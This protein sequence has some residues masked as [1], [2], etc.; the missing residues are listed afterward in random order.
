ME[1]KKLA[2]DP[3]KT[4]NSKD[5][6]PV[7][8]LHGLNAFIM[9]K[10]R[11]KIIQYSLSDEEKEFNL[12]IYD[13]E[14]T[15]IEQVIED[16]ETL[17]FLGDK[18]VV[19]AKNAFFLT[20]EKSKSKVEHDVSKLQT[21][22]EQPAPFSTLIVQAPY[23]K[24][25]ERKKIT[26]AL[27]KQA[28]Y[29]EANELNEQ[30]LVRW[31]KDVLHKRNV[32]MDE[33]AKQLLLQLV[34]LNVTIITNEVEKM[35]LYVGDNGVITRE[36]VH[37]LVAKTLEQNVFTL[38]EAVMNKNLKEALNIYQDLLRNNEEPIKIL[39]LL[40]SQFRLIYHTK[41]LSGQGYGQQQIAQTLKVHPFRVKIS[42]Q[43]S[44]RFEEP[45]LRNII[46]EL[47][48]ADYE[49]KTGKIDKALLLQLFFLKQAGG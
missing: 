8:L 48:E 32:E 3:L 2:I 16:A 14:E 20:A 22:L 12:S 40:A 1:R 35:M 31:I 9:K 18:R 25:D 21:Y 39:S 45:V 7:Y 15:P 37:E 30:D 47:A 10:A 24:L 6:K 42:L 33:D 36:V 41:Q 4:I 19:I 11:D 28:M 26:K 17:P 38:I 46:K 5:I 27:K 43:Q 34:G 13:L 23:E 29:V 49:M 44:R